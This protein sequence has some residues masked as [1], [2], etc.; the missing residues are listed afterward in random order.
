MV[1]LF[2]YCFQAQD[3][4][5][6]P[7]PNQYVAEDPETVFLELDFHR[8]LTLN[9]SSWENFS[10]RGFGLDFN[11]FAFP[12]LT[13]GAQYSYMGGGLKESKIANTGNIRRVRNHFFGFHAGYY[14]AFNREWNYHGQLGFGEVSNTNR[15]PDSRFTEN[16]NNL[17]IRNT[18]AYRLD[19]T[20]AFFLKT[21]IRWDRLA[22]EAPAGLDDY[23]NKHS[24]LLL[25]FGVRIN[26]QN[27]GG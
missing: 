27:P 8:M 12:F 11:W 22:I 1:V 26:F 18:V 5:P 23:F 20:M 24:L 25:G 4:I 17:F 21:T 9:D 2:P 14:H 6:E 7:H 15:S 16:G 19:R 13:I 3:S 10:T